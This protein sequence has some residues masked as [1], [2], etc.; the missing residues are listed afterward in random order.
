MS[1]HKTHKMHH[2]NTNH[3]IKGAG[4]PQALAVGGTRPSPAEGD[5]F[6]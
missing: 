2:D 1:E 5:P 6:P 4:S 3:R